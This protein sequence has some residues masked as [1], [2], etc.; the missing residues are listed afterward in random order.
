ML[1]VAPRALARF[2][3]LDADHVT[4]RTRARWPGR[5]ALPRAGLAVRSTRGAAR[6]HPRRPGVVGLGGA[7]FPTAGK[8]SVARDLLVLNGAECEPWI[9]CDDA[10]LREHADEV[11]RGG[12]LMARMVGAGARA[13]GDRGHHGRGAGRRT[14]GGR[15]RAKAQVEVVAVPTRYPEGGERQLIQVLTGR[16]VPRGG[17]PRDIG[18]IVQNVAT[19]R[20]AWRAVA[21][22]RAAG[23]ARGDG[24][25][26]AA[27]RG[28]ATSS[29]RSARRWRTWW[30]RP[31][32]IPPP[33]RACCWAAR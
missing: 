27:W 15:S 26:A 20:A 9:A 1:A 29:C 21:H 12:R 2:P 33:R 7:G 28:R 6:A 11:V 10:L 14:R 18:V 17:L 30:R 5:E 22:G 24:D 31:A 4:H 3:G 19:A 16:E 23:V 32:A 13:A 25:R 8:L